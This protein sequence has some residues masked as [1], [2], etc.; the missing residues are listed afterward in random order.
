M[1]VCQLNQASAFGKCTSKCYCK[2]CIDSQDGCLQE[3]WMYSVVGRV[4][5]QQLCIAQCWSVF[6]FR[7]AFALH[8]GHIQIPK[9]KCKT[10]LVKMSFICTRIKYHFHISDLALTFPLKQWFGA[11]QKWPIYC[12]VCSVLKSPWIL[13]EVLEKSLNFIFPWKV[14]KFLCTSPWNV[15]KF[16]PNLTVVAWKVLFDAFWLS[17]TGYESSIYCSRFYICY[18][19]S[20]M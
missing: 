3:H 1:Q 19:C 7:T 2:P 16:S 14:L 6:F 5:C 20:Y 11:T 10:Y 9:C 4:G 17:K 8:E 13:G 12:R 18:A 15:L